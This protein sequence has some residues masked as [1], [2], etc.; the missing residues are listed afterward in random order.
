MGQNVGST[1]EYK[2]AIWS[3]Y[4]ECMVTC[5]VYFILDA[6]ARDCHGNPIDKGMK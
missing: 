4:V 3:K 6:N 5:A 2:N 1:S